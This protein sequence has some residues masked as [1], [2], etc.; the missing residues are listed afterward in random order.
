MGLQNEDWNRLPTAGIKAQRYLCGYCGSKV[1]SNK[2]DYTGNGLYM[3]DGRLYICPEC[4][5]PTF[6]HN[7]NQ[8]P[9]G[10]PGRE[11]A[12]LPDEIKILYKEAQRCVSVNSFTACVLTCRKILMHVSHERGA[13]DKPNFFAYIQYLDEAH[14]IPPNGRGWI[15]YIRKQG[16][17]ANHEIVISTKENAVALLNLT[18]M[19]LLNIYDLPNRVPTTEEA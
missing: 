4:N 1:S 12:N 8:T 19:L 5:C 6:I 18:E 2:G 10:I 16:N 17:K 15:D 7:G 14:Y 13:G 3:D 9:G 11:I